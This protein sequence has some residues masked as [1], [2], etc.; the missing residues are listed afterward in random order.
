MLELD[1]I[2]VAYFETRKNKRKSRDQVEFEVH[3]EMNCMCLY[4]DII[5][6]NL[7]PTAYTFVTLKPQPREIFASC[8]RYRILHHL[9]HM[10]LNELIENKLSDR[11]FNNRKGMGPITCWERIIEDIYDVSKGFT[12]D[13][14]I[15]KLDIKGCFPNMNQD[16]AYKLLE[17][18]IINE[19]RGDDKEDLTYILQKCIYSYPA[20]HCEK[21]GD[22]TNWSILD[23]EKSQFNKPPGIGAAPGHLIW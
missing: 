4:Q 17:D 14:W 5:D 23:P 20:L 10:R 11:T 6:R 9:L 21:R 19:Y 13:V 3:W 16:I 2:F 22:I 1:D 7:H 18:I 15:V 12:H 8:F